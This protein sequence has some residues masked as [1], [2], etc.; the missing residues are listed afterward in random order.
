MFV[1]RRKTFSFT[2][3]TKVL[4]VVQS[5]NILTLFQG[6]DK[7]ITYQLSGNFIG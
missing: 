5:Y 4:K 7:A 1:Q 6:I 2:K 3:N